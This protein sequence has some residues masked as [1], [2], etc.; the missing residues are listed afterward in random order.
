VAAEVYASVASRLARGPEF[1][2]TSPLA[3]GLLVHPTRL[4]DAVLNIFVLDSPQDTKVDVRDKLTGVRLTLLDQHA[5][6]V[7]IGQKIRRNIAKYGVRES[8]YYSDFGRGPYFSSLSFL[9]TEKRYS[10]RFFCVMLFDCSHAIAA[11]I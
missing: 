3:S 7:L 2:A 8:R 11:L 9:N 6:M 1:E 10:K 5:A 4:D